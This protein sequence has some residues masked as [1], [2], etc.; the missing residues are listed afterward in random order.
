MNMENT[1]EKLERLMNSYVPEFAYKKDGNDAGSVLS[2]LCGSMLEE[3]VKR[4][5]RVIPK[6]RIQYLNMFNSFLKEPVSASKGYVQ[7][8][9]VTGYTGM[10]PVPKKTRVMAT[11]VAEEEL[12]F[13][14]EHDVTVSDTAPEWIVVTDRNTDRIV[15]HPYEEKKKEAF[16]AFDIRG[17]NCA[18]HRLYL[19]F[20]ELFSSLNGLDF[21][22]YVEAFSEADQ[23]MLLE[24]LCSSGVR[25]AMLDPQQ[26]ECFFSIVEINNG[27][28]HLKIDHYSPKKV[29]LGQKEAYFLILFQM[30][31]SSDLEKN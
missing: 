29:V 3:C 20:D 8:Q 24:T 21:Y 14:T 1:Y 17:E 13:E 22:V 4:Y 7:F 10:V 9:P 12:I 11:G 27:A 31:L 28:I 23:Q 15:V 6:H 25:W 2:N 16:F 18:E 19:G 5:D 26:G 30:L